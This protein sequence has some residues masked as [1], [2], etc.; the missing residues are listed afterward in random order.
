MASSFTLVSFSP[1]E[2]IRYPE[3]LSSARFNVS[4]FFASLPLSP[5]HFSEKKIKKGDRSSNVGPFPCARGMD[6]TVGIKPPE[7]S[8]FQDTKLPRGLDI[9]SFFFFF[10]LPAI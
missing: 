5:F 1:R 10:H 7:C 2:K 3:W 9:F 6:D 8:C 4:S